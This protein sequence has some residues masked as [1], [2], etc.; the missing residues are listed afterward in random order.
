[1]RWPTHCQWKKLKIVQFYVNFYAFK[2]SKS[3]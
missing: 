1:L 3:L 2:L